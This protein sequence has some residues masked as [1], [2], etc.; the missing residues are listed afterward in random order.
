MGKYLVKRILFSIL[1]LI[2]VVGIV[3]LLVYTAIHRNVIFQTDDLWNKKNLND[4]TMYEY[5]LYQKYGYLTYVD[6]GNFLKAK[7]EAQFGP[8]YDKQK[9]Y[10]DD[11]ASIKKADTYEQNA[12]VQEFK[13]KYE[14]MGYEIVYLEP[15]TYKNGRQK[16]GGR[17]YLIAVREGGVGI[18]RPN[19]QLT[20]YAFTRAD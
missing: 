6:F 4:R 10:V 15:V 8:E 2:V 20:S 11:L 9:E 19:F 18:S 14:G 5:S 1:S 12:S 3:M 17:P 7:Y 16:P 13:A